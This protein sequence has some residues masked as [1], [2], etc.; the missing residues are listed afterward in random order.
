MQEYDKVPASAHYAYIINILLL[1]HVLHVL[2][3]KTSLRTP[4][5]TSNIYTA[6]P[7]YSSSLTLKKFADSP[8]VDEAL[9]KVKK[10]PKW[11]YGV[12]VPVRGHK[13]G[14][15]SVIDKRRL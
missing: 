6:N 2:H 14:Q 13:W 11:N 10:P 9:R 4:R 1:L 3:G 8:A 15:M 7:L 12:E 5:Q